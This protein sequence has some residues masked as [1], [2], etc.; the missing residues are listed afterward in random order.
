MTQT[1][2]NDPEMLETLYWQEGL[3]M[4]RIAQRLGC[5]ETAV[6]NAMVR[7]GIDRRGRRG[8]VDTN[9]VLFENRK[10][11]YVRVNNHH[12]GEQHGFFLHQLV[13]I[14]KGVDPHKVFSEE[15]NT[16]HKNEVRWD[17]R[18]EN[19]ELMTRRNHMKHHAEDRGLGLGKEYS[20]TEMIEWL[21]SFVRQFGYVPTS[22]DVSGWPGPSRGL[23]T[24]RFGSWEN[25]LNEA[26]WKVPDHP[27][28][29]NGRR[30][31]N[32]EPKRYNGDNT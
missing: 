29:K 22:E 21:N 26:G 30:I 4:W 14:S 6:R 20:D 18:P 12:N 27:T 24:Q 7:F 5:S 31:V 32:E 17:N 8:K 9:K 23:Y 2:V 10:D 19:L 1:V 16:H 15:Y 13:L 25:A 11:G 28:D 3:S